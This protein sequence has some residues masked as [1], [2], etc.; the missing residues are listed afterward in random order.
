MKEIRDNCGWAAQTDNSYQVG[1]YRG[2]PDTI[3]M[4]F[5]RPDTDNTGNLTT[6]LPVSI[7]AF[8]TLMALGNRLL[9]TISP[10]P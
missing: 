5:Q 8:R 7:E 3:V 9:E 2:A 4:L 1:L 6:M 10:K